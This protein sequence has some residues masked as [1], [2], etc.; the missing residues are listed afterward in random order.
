VAPDSA[1][2]A[3]PQPA[4]AETFEVFVLPQRNGP[5]L[6]FTGKLVDA[7]RTP[8]RFGRWVEL[9]V[10]RTKGGKFVGVQ[11]KRSML[12]GEVDLCETQVADKLS[13][14]VEFFGHS[15]IAKVL[16]DRLGIRSYNDI[17]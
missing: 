7:V 6:R 10:Y 12:L 8:A 16:T 15:P 11:L 9:H 17:E 4:P 1:T 2:L 3:E 13:D 5:D 14:L